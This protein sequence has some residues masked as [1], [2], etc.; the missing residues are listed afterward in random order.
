MFGTILAVF[1]LFT[2][3]FKDD[4]KINEET[5]LQTPTEETLDDYPR[6]EN[7]YSVSN[8]K[9][10]LE[11]LQNKS[12]K[13]PDNPYAAIRI[14]PTHL[15]VKFTPRNEEELLAVKRDTLI[16][17]YDHPLDVEDW[18]IRDF[19]NFNQD[20]NRP[21]ELWAAVKVDHRL[22]RGCPSRILER[23]HIPDELKTSP[24]GKN[25]TA[26]SYLDKL[27]EESLQLT[28]NF[29]DTQT[30]KAGKWTPS[31]NIKASN[32]P[33]QGIK[34]RARRWFTTHVGYTKWNGDFTCDGQF[35]RP[36]NYSLIYERKSVFDIRDGAFGQANVDGPKIQG[37]WIYNS[38]GGRPLNYGYVYK[39][40]YDYFYKNPFGTH[41]PPS[42][43][44][45]QNALKI[46]Y[47]HKNGGSSFQAWKTWFTATTLIAIAGG[48]SFLIGPLVPQAITTALLLTSTNSPIKIYW[49]N[50][51]TTKIY[52][53]TAHELAHAAHWKLIIDAVNSNRWSDYQLAKSSLTEG[54]AIFM[55]TRFTRYFVSISYD[56]WPE[57]DYKTFASFSNYSDYFNEV[58]DK[59]N[60]TVSQMES[61]LIGASSIPEWIE[62]VKIKYNSNDTKLEEILDQYTFTDE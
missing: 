29:D 36:A 18:V 59:T 37:K 48:A 56:R 55:E 26:F 35:K 10:A 9:K 23:L 58:Y 34:V 19:F 44:G 7:P 40:A 60:Y 43:P 21:P 16:E 4:P 46:S 11:S 49:N 45:L 39:A 15:Y 22:P 30:A 5:Q 41:S 33:L 47:Y 25:T 3:C 50:E 14:E 12:G 20:D 28:G 54:W 53:V 62:N 32:R 61:A 2:H 57:Y 52:A 31:G 27:V 8:M 17:L 6:L 13:G 24:R 1:V 42:S 38:T 51:N